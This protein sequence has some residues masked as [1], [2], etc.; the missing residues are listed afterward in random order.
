[1]Y[2]RITVVQ[3]V[4][5]CIDLYFVSY[6]PYPARTPVREQGQGQTPGATQ[7]PLLPTGFIHGDQSILVPVYPPDALNQYMSGAQDGQTSTSALADTHPSLPCQPPNVWRPYL[8]SAFTPGVPIPSGIQHP[9]AGAFPMV[10]P[11]GL[12]SYH[13]LSGLIW[14][15]SAQVLQRSTMFWCAHAADV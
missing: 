1:M 3:I 6:H 11:Q 13:W 7:V 12:M 4:S 8:P 15:E 14:H 2:A 9:I 5:N 10:G